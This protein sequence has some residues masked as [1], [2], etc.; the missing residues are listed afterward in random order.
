MTME[1]E[2]EVERVKVWV[3]GFGRISLEDENVG[4]VLDGVQIIVIE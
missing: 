3:E 1:V 4:F 2:V